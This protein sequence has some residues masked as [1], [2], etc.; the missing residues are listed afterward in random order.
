MIKK[1]S[2]FI[3]IL[4]FSILSLNITD[5]IK[6]NKKEKIKISNEELDISFTKVI[7]NRGGK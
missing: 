4:L 5:E 1:I 7:L 2:L 6:N 3:I